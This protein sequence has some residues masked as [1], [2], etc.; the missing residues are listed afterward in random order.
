MFSKKNSDRWLV[1]LKMCDISGPIFIDLTIKYR[2]KKYHRTVKIGKNTIKSLE[3]VPF[4]SYIWIGVIN[5]FSHEEVEVWSRRL[6]AVLG[7][8]PLPPP[9]PPRQQSCQS[10]T[11]KSLPHLAKTQREHFSTDRT[12][13]HENTAQLTGLTYMRMLLSWQYR[14]IIDLRT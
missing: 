11:H 3:T 5:F 10:E 13:I 8:T 6:A 1:I 12:D 7:Y 14:S 2:T 4:T 9:P